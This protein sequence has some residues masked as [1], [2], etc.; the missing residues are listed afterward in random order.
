MFEAIKL[1]AVFVLTTVITLVITPYIKKLAF[2]IG[3]TDQPNER[4]THVKIMPRLG[5]LG[6]VIGT[7]VGL[8][9]LQPDIDHLWSVIIG[10]LIITAVGV[11][12]DLYTIRPS[13][14]F[15][16]Q[17]IAALIVVFSGLTIDTLTLPII[18]R[19]ELGFLS[20]VITIFWI[21]G[22]TNAINLIDGLDGLAAG[23][24]II[25]MSSMFVISLIDQQL[26]VMQLLLVVIG[27]SIGFL[28]HNFFP[29]KIFMGDTGALFLGYV[30]SII[31][32]LG[33]FKNVTLFSFIVPIIIMAVPIFDTLFAII[34]RAISGQR[35]GE[36][37]KKH[38]HH[39]LI[40]MGYSHRMTVLIIYGFSLFFGVMAILFTSVTV[41]ISFVFVF[42]VLL[43]IQL[44][45]EM[46]GILEG[47]NRPVTN[48]IKKTKHFIHKNKKNTKQNEHKEK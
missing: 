38:I 46:T 31:S 14:K 42:F 7:A 30:I 3:A 25:G 17:L 24:S 48:Q 37:D 36:A 11:L 4:K 23:V 5:G 43:G 47:K 2:K 28:Y 8:L 33:L 20:T 15:S 12:D 32:I 19:F 39:K 1:I 22:V 6:I 34:R 41:Q 27:P 40:A 29:A 26:A 16:G 9:I 18:G 44:I 21:V 35:I 10:G 13:V 45:A